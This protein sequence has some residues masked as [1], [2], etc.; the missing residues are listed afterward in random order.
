M[1][2]EARVH[3]DVQRSAFVVSDLRVAAVD[4]R[5]L[6][7]PVAVA[8]RSLH[9][10]AR[11]HV[12]ADQV[13]AYSVVTEIEVAYGELAAGNQPTALHVLES[14]AERR[15]IEAHL[16]RR[17]RGR[18]ALTAFLDAF[19]TDLHAPAPEP[20]AQLRPNALVTHGLDGDLVHVRVLPAG[21]LSS[22]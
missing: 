1:L 10:V 9:A 21:R 13:H 7:E 19:R 14:D 18:G 3:V 22:S 20:V 2:D 16:R 11:R 5:V 4:Q 15:L 17:R 6:P 12:R 8:R